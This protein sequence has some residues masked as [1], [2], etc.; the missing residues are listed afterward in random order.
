MEIKS[1]MEA[2]AT[3]IHVVRPALI[4]HTKMASGDP[5]PLRARSLHPPACSEHTNNHYHP[6]KLESE[7]HTK[8]RTAARGRVCDELWV[9]DVISLVCAHFVIC[10]Q[11]QQLMYPQGCY[12]ENL[13]EAGDLQEHYK[14]AGARDAQL[15]AF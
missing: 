15:S 2:E 1:W 13:L 4:R 9:R 7:T 3:A 6:A 8:P 12:K 11:G 10:K 5:A 14:I